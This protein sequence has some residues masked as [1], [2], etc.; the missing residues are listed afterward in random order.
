MGCSPHT[1]NDPHGQATGR[2]QLPLKLNP[3]SSC[4]IPIT[5]HAYLL[6]S[7]FG[8]LYSDR[9]L[10]EDNTPSSTPIPKAMPIDSY[11]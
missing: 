7:D 6:P 1:S 10:R 2:I 4:R 9:R 8:A 3:I 11:G 5:G